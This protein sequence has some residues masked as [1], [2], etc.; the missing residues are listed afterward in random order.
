MGPAGSGKSTLAKALRSK[1]PNSQIIPIAEGVKDVARSLGWNGAKD[2]KGRWLL[3]HIGTELGRNF[4]GKFWWIKRW[5][6][7]VLGS[8]ADVII[9]DDL[10]FLNEQ[11]SGAFVVKMNSVPI[12]WWRL[13]FNK[14]LRHAS[15]TEHKRIRHWN[16]TAGTE[17][18]VSEE[19]FNM[20]IEHN[21][22]Q[23][24]EKCLTN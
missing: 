19:V 23:I 20:I 3:Q 8:G 6:A 9:C 14:R 2:K 15:E 16:Y 5:E 17:Y 4:G 22:N 1:I 7:K 18:K 24:I 12:P 10:R 13:L 11:V 21:A